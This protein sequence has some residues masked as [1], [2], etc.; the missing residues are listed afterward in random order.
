FFDI[1]QTAGLTGKQGVIIPTANMRHLMLKDEVVAAAM[2]KKFHIYAV[3]TV[4]E[5][6]AL[7]TGL[8]AGERGKNKKF[9]QKK[10]NGRIEH[11]LAVFAKHREEKEKI[12]R[13][14][15]K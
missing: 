12:K 10:L 8:P 11:R 4:D 3:S 1:C 14:R 9:P 13:V 2:H 6:I 7:L 15:K 5:M